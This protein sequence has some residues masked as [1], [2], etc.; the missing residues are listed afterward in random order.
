[1]RVLGR[2]VKFVIVFVIVLLIVLIAF[3]VTF[4][5][6]N[7]KPQ[8]IAQV[9]KA[10]GRDF[11]IAGDINLSVFPWIGLKVEDV[12]LGNEKGFAAKYFAAI[13]Q[14]DIKVNVLPLLK[15]E[16]EINTIRLHGLNLA[17]EVAADKSNNWSGLTQAEATAGE[18]DKAVEE[19]APAAEGAGLP[20]QSLQVAGF[21]FVDA[22]ILYEDRSS[23]TRATVS[24]LNL[25]TGAIEFDRPVEVSFAAHIKNEQPALDSRLKLE[26][27]LTFNKQ[28][29]VFSVRDFVMTVLT[30]ANEF[31]KQDEQL[32][33]KTSI[34]VSM[35]AQRITVKPLQLSALG[36]TTV[37]DV[38]VSQFQQ[39]PVIQ[40]EI[41][42]LPFNAREI[43]GRVGVV[44]PAMAKAD[45]LQRVTLKTK[46]NMQGEKLEANDFSL[47]LDDS[48]LS[49]WLHVIDIAK[50]QLRY[51]LAFD[52]LNVDDYLPPVA[53]P[54]ANEKAV[55][56]AAGAETSAAAASSGDEKIE[57]PLEMM[58][59]LDI[60]GDFRIASLSAMKYDIKQFSMTTKAQQG[61]INIKPISM[62]VLE[63]QVTSA[64]KMNVQKPIPSYAID[65][66][67]N[68]LQAGPVANPFLVGVM[69]DEELSLEGAVNV[70]MAVKTAGETVNQL[71][72]ASL[73]Q[74]VLDMKETA[75]KGFDPEYYMRSSV[76]NYLDSKGFGQSQ[77]IT[78]SYQP[79]QVTVFDTIHSTVN[80]KDGKARTDDFL[81][82][83]ERV[84][85]AA[86]GYV[87]IM[88][89]S[90]DVTS[91]VKL[92]RGQTA[93]EKVLDEPVF[94]HVHGPFAALEY[95]LDTAQ[96]KKS[97]TDVLEKEAKAKLDA[98]KQRLKEKA[99]AEKQRLKDKADEERRQA[100]EKA[101]QELKDSTE[102]YQDKLKDKLKGLF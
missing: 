95:D 47:K 93:L 55:A 66:D 9:E 60:Q 90:V 49:G 81:M 33:V 7:Y 57:L 61:E 18:A 102:K 99:E 54:A 75:V 15:K 91:S 23:K 25:K 78:G 28:F 44:L 30:S 37:V 101:R 34:D 94:V 67:L 41:E 35:E 87:D 59:Q 2:L 97:T 46:I 11:S 39:T 89:N 45:A 22:V 62:Q 17:L 10:T 20:L 63:G 4:D 96:L 69:G 14:L 98:E 80:L 52:H 58:R 74:I 36:T 70:V 53:E 32:E 86:K 64:L 48:T 72:Q 82:D 31:I 6:N 24:D 79:R 71:K 40:G 29:T 88:Q 16:V 77:S 100:E 76:S 68:Q 21:E 92:P 3:A 5:A 12:T 8:I 13:K 1:M 38:T 84:Q 51:D 73:G 50:Q 27:T 85:V 26:T 42:V 43:A 56:A 83:S 65:L 19:K